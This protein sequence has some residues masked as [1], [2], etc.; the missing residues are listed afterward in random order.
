M[1][2]KN[3]N[4]YLQFVF[5]YQVPYYSSN[6]II[7]QQWSFIF[8]LATTYCQLFCIVLVL[9][10]LNFHVVSKTY[11][12]LKCSVN[13]MMY[14]IFYA[15]GLN[16]LWRFIPIVLFCLILSCMRKLKMLRSY[17]ADYAYAMS[18]YFFNYMEVSI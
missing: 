18:M 14:P 2:H 15:I 6:T 16:D 10:D 3:K 9:K 17:C 7:P 13:W 12:S 1:P 11:A 4:F 8:I 5:L